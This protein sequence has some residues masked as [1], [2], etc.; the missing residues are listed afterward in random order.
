AGAAMMSCQKEAEIGASYQNES[1]RQSRTEGVRNPQT[2]TT[3]RV[4]QKFAYDAKGKL[5]SIYN[6]GRLQKRFEYDSEER[7][8]TLNLAESGQEIH[9]RYEIDVLPVDAI[10][11]KRFSDGSAIEFSDIVF[12]YDELGRKVSE[13]E[14]ERET[15]NVISYLY[16]YDE[17]DRLLSIQKNEGDMM[18]SLTRPDGFVE[19]KSHLAGLDV[20]SLE[21][22]TSLQ[23]GL[24]VRLMVDDASGHREIEYT[25]ALNTIGQ[26][27]LFTTSLDGRRTVKSKVTY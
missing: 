18:V 14:T 7:L 15:G 19:G 3:N 10:R 25:Y 4:D 27:D 13:I 23:K 17:L 8:I 6:A 22:G 20:L 2:I 21:P 24:P 12:G 16:E 5:E 1:I 26:P 9:Y 11:V